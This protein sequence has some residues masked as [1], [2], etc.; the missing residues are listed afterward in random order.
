MFKNVVNRFL[1][2]SDK[3]KHVKLYFDSLR[4]FYLGLKDKHS[5]E[6]SEFL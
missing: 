2:S 3:S 1:S 5:P 6:E 4:F